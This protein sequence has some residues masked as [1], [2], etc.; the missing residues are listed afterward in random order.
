MNDDVTQRPRPP[1]QPTPPAPAD[2]AVRRGSRGAGDGAAVS[3]NGTAPGDTPGNPVEASEGPFADG[4]PREPRAAGFGSGITRLA[5]QRPLLMLMAITAVMILGLIGYRRMGVDLFPAVNFP[6]VLVSVPYPGAGPEVVETLVTKPV[7]DAVAGL[8]D[9]DRITSFSSEGLS[10]VT[11]QF[12]D[13]AD[14]Q[15]VAIEVE[16]RVNAAR[17]TLP[18]D[19]LPPTILKFD[20]NQQPIM[21]LAL[22]GE[23]SSEQLFRIAD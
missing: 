23:R 21:N 8:A 4:M 11:V 19:V 18:T 14:P 20:F 22:S 7:E 3:R 6:V 10:T 12:K 16:K 17:A 13:Q 1:E 15:T 5:I 9:L 2:R